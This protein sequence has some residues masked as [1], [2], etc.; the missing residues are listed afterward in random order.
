MRRYLA[1]LLMCLALPAFAQ[2]DYHKTAVTRWSGPGRPMTY[3][4]YLSAN[5]ALP[6]SWSEV[7]RL[8]PATDLTGPVLVVVQSSLM[9]PLS[10]EI[11]R[12]LSDLTA[13]GW[14]PILLS[15]T[16]G[17]YQQL[18]TVLQQYQ[19]GDSIL[20]AVLVGDLPQAWYEL[21]EDFDNNGL[22]DPPYTMVQFPCD[23]YYMDLDGEWYDGNLN[24]ILDT[25][26]GAWE[27]DVFVGRI[28][29]STLPGDPV[30]LIRN[31]FNKNH[32]FRTHQLYLPGQGLAYIDDDWAGGASQWAAAMAQGVGLVEQVSDPDSTRAA[33]YI[34][35][36]DDGHYAYLLAS[37]SWPQGHSLKEQGGTVWNSVT[38][39]QITQ[40]DPHGF[41]YNLFCCSAAR[42]CES[43]YI[44]GCYLFTNTYSVE[45][46]GSAKTG[47][48]L[49]FEDYYSQIQN[50]ECQGEAL[51]RWFAM[52]GHEPGSVMW[53]M[54]WFYGMTEL[55]DPTLFMGVGVQVSSVE[56]IDDGTQGSDGDGDGIPDGGETIVLNLTLQNNDPVTY[57]DVSVKLTSSNEQLFDIFIDSVFV[58]ALPGSGTAHADGFKVFVSH[59]ISD[60][61]VIAVS[62]QIRDNA[63]HLWGDNFNLTVRNQKLE[64]TG[65]NLT[66]ISGDNDP[67]AE[68]GETFGVNLTVANQGG[69][70]SNQA[71][72]QISSLGTWLVPSGTS[73]GLPALN[74]GTIGSTSTLIS[75]HIL[76]NCPNPHGEVLRAQIQQGTTFSSAHNFIFPVGNQ[77]AWTDSIISPDAALIHYP[78][79]AGYADQWHVTGLRT[80]SPPYSRKCGHPGIVPYAPMADGALETPLFILGA[81]SE[82]RFRHWMAA[83][84]GYDGGIIEINTGGGWERLTPEGGYPGTSQGNGSYP[85]GPC[86]NG[87]I[88]WAQAVFD[89]SGYQGFARLRFRFGSDSGTELEGWYVDNVQITGPLIAPPQIDVNLSPISAP[90]TI[91]AN[92][93]SFNFN[94]MVRNWGPNQL[95]YTVWTRIKYPDGSYT[96]PLL[97]PITLNSP[98]G[99]SV[100]RL[101]TQSIPGN[102]PPGAYSYLGYGNWTYAYP[103]LDSSSFAFTKLT[104]GAGPW[105]TDASCTGEPF[106]GEEAVSTL[107]SAFSLSEAHPN[108]FNPSTVASF[109]LRVASQVSL[110]A[111]DTA[112]RLVATL[113]DGW[114]EAGHHQVTF[115]GSR[116]ASGLYFV[117]MQAGEFSAVKKMMLVK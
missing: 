38:S 75:V 69:N 63:Q 45:V 55:G 43:N 62:A 28:L 73:V 3:E 82:L 44:A 37:H 27:P 21:Y 42:F 24:G 65:Y 57:N 51:R 66:Q 41:F 34:S 84:T 13:A 86:Y 29:A 8:H 76:S 30:E 107:P 31:Y 36:L 103:A 25:H 90:I 60:S 5:P 70:Q 16:G 32:A 102:W 23:L 26:L 53:A 95:P 14:E 77:V 114:R 40:N 110:K 108:P 19:V 54:S 116:L 89:L 12:Y 46:I 93:G 104:T 99:V 4:E 33:D 52:H 56:V 10:L 88:N 17:T 113:V 59:N 22:P 68:P 80:Y 98:V 35:R 58:G 100:T 112:G 6:L 85:G 64:L 79:T 1:L 7:A 117:K 92:G 91:P 71:T 74:P 67:W 47:S 96:D 11:N 39:N 20:G 87:E 48:M 111:Y 106:P 50:G 101:R 2:F 61:T 78:V 97:G 83:E 94:A 18:R 9:T 15:W 72:L 49:Y 105:V 109:E 115:D 81:S